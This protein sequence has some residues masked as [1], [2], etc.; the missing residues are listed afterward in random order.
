MKTNNLIIKLIILLSIFVSSGWAGTSVTP[1]P[2]I[3]GDNFKFYSELT[4]DLPSGYELRI[5]I[6]DGGGGYHSS[7]KMN[8]SKKYFY[9]NTTI[10]STGDNRKF[11]VAVFKSGVKKTDWINRTYSVKQKQETQ[12]KPTISISSASSSVTQGSNYQIK[13]SL[14]DQNS[15]LKNVQ[16]NWGD[17]SSNSV[18]ELSGGSSTEYISHI[19]NKTGSF[20]WNATVY[21]HTSRSNSKSK[22][23]SVSSN[24]PS[25]PSIN[26]VSTSPSTIYSGDNV[27]FKANLSKSVPNGYSIKLLIDGASEKTMNCSGS[28]CTYSNTINTVGTNRKYTVYVKYNGST[29]KTK[30][31]YYDVKQKQETQYKP[32]ISISSASSSVT[33]GS[34]YQIKLSLKDQNSD[35]KN[36]QVNWGDGSSNSVVELSGGSSTEYISH[37]YNK[38]GSFTWNATV[39]DHT[40]RSNSKSKSVSVSSNVPSAPSI[41]SVSTSPSTI[42]SGDNV[43]FKANLSKSVPNGYSIKLLIDGAS[44][45]TMN[46]SGSTCT[47]SNTINTVG[48]NRKYTVYVKYNGSTKK[49]KYGYY[50]VK[51]KQ[52]TQYKPT[53]SISSASSSVTQGSNYQIK[54]SLK[55]Q[56]SDLKNVQVNWGDGS[57]NSVV[58]LSGGSSTEYISHIYNKTGSFT[59]NATVYDHT[60]RSNSKSKSVSVSEKP[61]EPTSDVVNVTPKYGYSGD[62][63]KFYTNLKGNLPSGYEVKIEI[64]DGGGGYLSSKKM[65][66]SGKYF[67]YSAAITS[68]GDKRKYRIAIFKNNIKKTDWVNGT[69]KVISNKIIITTLSPKNAIKDSETIFM[70][71]GQNLPTTIALSLEDGECKEPFNITSTSASIKCIPRTVGVN[72]RFYV[73]VT[74]GGDAIEGSTSLYV[75]IADD[76]GSGLGQ[77]INKFKYFDPYKTKAIKT[78]LENNTIKK[79]SIYKTK[80][81]RAEATILVENFLAYKSSKFKNKDMSEYYMSF[82]DVDTQTDYYNSLLKLSYYIGDNDNTTPISKENKLFRPLDKVSRQEFIAIVV[83]GFDLDIVDDNSSISGFDDFNNGTIAPWAYKYFNTAVKNGL[84][85][86]NN[87]KLLPKDDLSVYESLVILKRVYE[88]LEGKYKHTEAKFQSADSLDISKLLF[89]QI[90]Y[91]YEPIYFQSNAT[92]ISIKNVSQSTANKEY[93]GID[94]SIVLSVTSTTDS[95]E[96][97]KVNEYYWW[98]TNAGYFREYKGS[99][100]FKKICFIPATSKPSEGYKIVVN[101]GDN[102]GYVDKYTYTAININ[103]SKY[104]N[105]NDKIDATDN[106]TFGGSKYM[107][108]NKAYSINVMGG[109]EKAGTNVGI[110]NIKITLI[111]GSTQV[112]LFK[113]QAINGKATFIVPD[114]PELYGEN[115]DIQIVAHTQ[116]AISNSTMSNVRYIPQFTLRGK[117]YNANSTDKADYVVVGNDKIY[118]DENNEF[119]KVLDKTYEVKSLYIKVHSSSDKNSFESLKVD[120]TY[121][122]PS[123]F[124]VMVGEDSTLSIPIDGDDSTGENKDTDGD[125]IKDSEEGTKDSDNDGIPDYKDLDSDNDGIVDKVEGATDTDGDGKADYLDTDSDNDGISDREEIINGT[126]PLVSNIYSLGISKGTS[127]ISGNIVMSK[128]LNKDIGI[129]WS[130]APSYN[131]WM[132]YSENESLQDKILKYGYPKLNE[133]YENEGLFIV[134]SKDST[135]NMLDKKPKRYFPQ[136]YPPTLEESRYKYYVDKYPKGYSLHGTNNTIDTN[137]ITCKDNTILG[138]VL[139]LKEDS[140]SIYMPNQTIENMENFNYIYPNEGYMVWCYDENE[141]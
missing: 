66:G 76:D 44:E 87:N 105:S 17:G 57:S 140:W 61:D 7:K 40:S 51:Q 78:I 91:E 119:Y 124:L 141:Y 29:K 49:T 95:L 50:D 20:T 5:E 85:S 138:A 47:Y 14:K 73:G 16:V 24:V 115:I 34:N 92:G 89:K 127:L 53:I 109:F 129:V 96:T 4:K 126:N 9:Y 121:L 69:Y 70:V 94:N 137:S 130:L 120:L 118:L 122:N 102:I 90:G 88:K 114:I 77:F 52:E 65:E 3:A 13:L 2:G 108:A 63:F 101:G 46:C 71:T 58:E 38:T 81:S 62:T 112:E 54:L 107:T 64:G 15:D 111:N 42:Y 84:M 30:Y 33:Q 135:I 68:P 136:I 41:N 18:V 39:Y 123:R 22:S 25:A 132:G 45:K 72:K 27:T 93:C 99:T 28:T 35:L 133:S 23:V 97:S 113:G 83:Q 79:D 1:N 59:W 86:G 74:K 116:N 55:D 31:G 60:S 80:V 117:V 11:R 103:D 6:G 98:S 131:I 37:I 26:S 21:D 125:G 10:N 134:S 75:D 48:T 19:Y 104:D 32:T 8:G 106:P 128:H 100:N 82:A 36:V 56:N 67:S 139:K 43:T 12:Y 110:E